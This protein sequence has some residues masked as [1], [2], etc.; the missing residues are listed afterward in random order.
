MRKPWR[1]L[2]A[3]A[4]AVIAGLVV[5]TTLPASPASAA[6][7]TEVTGFGTNPTGIR[8]YLYVP[9]RLATKP[10]VLVAVHYCTGSGPAFYSG[11]EFKSLADQY[12]FIVIYPST[13]R[14]GNCWDVSSAGALTHNG[15]S[16]PVGITSMVKYVQQRYN[17][18]TARTFVT[19]ASSG[20]MMT[21]VLL[22]D[23]PDVFAGGAAFSGV[24]DTCFQATAGNPADPSQQAGWNSACASGQVI[25]TAAQ[26]GDAVRNSYPGYTGPRPRMQ[27][28][29]GATDT[30]LHYNNFGEEIKQW[31]NVHGVSQTPVKTDTPQSG[32]T[33]TWYGDT[34]AQPPVQAISI[35]GVGHSL[36]MAGQARMAISFFGLDATPVPPSS[37]SSPTPS[38]PSSSQPPVPGGCTATISLNSWTGGYVATVTV[39]AGSSA[40]NGW[41]VGTTLPSGSAITN[42]WSAT[43]SG[44]SGAVS[45]TNVNY[46]GSVGAG[47]ST[48]FGFQGTGTGPTS[49]TCTAR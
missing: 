21:N 48:Q 31:T 11:T 45:F 12:G 42:S 6:A 35:A 13:V 8:M 7:L 46:N 30:T 47:A 44:T 41:T 26:W 4:A 18:D 1:K 49:A 14:T 34:S 40:L 33:R 29:H 23:Y 20:A 43:G 32:W 9:D 22:A 25:K 16:D 39:K 5:A 24:P 38:T 10:A 27:L 36:P 3:A 37:P 17:T 19:G 28:W 2:L 15:N